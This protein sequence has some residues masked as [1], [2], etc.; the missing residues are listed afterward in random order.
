MD[1]RY[2]TKNSVWKIQRMCSLSIV[3]LFTVVCWQGTSL[4]EIL[5]AVIKKNVDDVRLGFHF[6][7]TAVEDLLFCPTQ[8]TS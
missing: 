6:L 8:W 7:V 3:F 2:A 4:S 5:S 1:F